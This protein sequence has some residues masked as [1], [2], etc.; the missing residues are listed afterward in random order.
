M[1]DGQCS[2]AVKF[3]GWKLTE[4]LKPSPGH[5]AWLRSNLADGQVLVDLLAQSEPDG[6]L[7]AGVR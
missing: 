3:K 7:L 4:P 1:L 5:M 2:S 6:W